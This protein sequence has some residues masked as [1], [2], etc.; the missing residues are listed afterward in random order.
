MPNVFKDTASYAQSQL[1][2]EIPR[3]VTEYTI[4]VTIRSMQCGAFIGSI[5]GPMAVLL[6]QKERNRQKYVDSFT[7][8]GQAGALVG[9]AMGPFLTYLDLRGLCDLVLYGKCY[10]LKFDE[11]AL[12]RDRAAVFSGAIGLLSSGA[13]GFILGLDVSF[14]FS[15][16]I[17]FFRSTD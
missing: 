6:T 9:A 8:G 16:M 3:P 11:D 4:H 1:D 15:K 5:L 10:S 7:R 2:P 13:P 17:N 12:R 14:V